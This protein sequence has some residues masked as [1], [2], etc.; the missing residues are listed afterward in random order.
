MKPGRL[1]ALL[2]VATAFVF[3]LG[4]ACVSIPHV[5]VLL[6]ALI[7]TW[8]PTNRFVLGVAVLAAALVMVVGGV[9]LAAAAIVGELTA[10]LLMVAVA[11]LV[12]AFTVGALALRGI[13]LARSTRR[14]AD[15]P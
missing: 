11:T 3:Y 15:A 13:S 7:L 4:C 6:L 8:R 12:L 10:W 14:A 1:A 2:L 9:A 5:V